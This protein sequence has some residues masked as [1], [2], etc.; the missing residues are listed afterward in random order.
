MNTAMAQ[1]QAG[2]AC[3]V[4]ATV[5]GT[6]LTVTADNAEVDLGLSPGVTYRIFYS[7]ADG[8][9]KMEPADNGGNADVAISWTIASDPN[10]NVVFDFNLPSAFSGETFGYQFPITYGNTDATFING[11]A[12]NPITA[13]WN[14]HNPS[15]VVN[16]TGG[17]AVFLGCTFN[18]PLAT[19]ADVYDATFYLAA[20]ATGF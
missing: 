19:P 6:A 9:G 16:L 10:T 14:P 8:A 12:G 5:G 3:K 20:T 17:D 2:D 7:P 4:V 1:N 18:V 13:V 15:P 11:G